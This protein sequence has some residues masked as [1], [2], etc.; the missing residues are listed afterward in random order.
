[1]PSI[2]EVKHAAERQA[3]GVMIDGLIKNLKN[4]DDRT[5]TYLKIVG[6]AQKYFGKAFTPEKVEKVKKDVSDPDNRWM[7]FINRTIDEINPNFAKMTLLNLGYEAFLRGTKMIRENREKYNCNIP[8][9]ILFD[10]TSACNMHCVGCWSGTYGH[11]N[12]LSFEDMDKIVTEG[13][14]L[15]VYL[16]LMT[17]GEPM[18]RKKD[19]LRLIEKHHDCY[20]AAF[21]NSTLI[22]EDF[23]KEL[24]RLGNM[25]FLLSIEGTPDTNDARRGTGHYAEVMRAM[26]LLKKYGILFG[27]SVCY[28][29]QNV[30]AVTSDDFF[31]LLEEKGAKFGFYFHYMPIGKNAVPALM[32]TPEQRKYMIDRIRYIR[33]DK[34]DIQFYPMDFQNDGEYVGGCIAGGRNYF[35]INSSGDAEPCVF[36]H[37]SNANIHDQSVL[38]ILKSPL[39]MMYHEGQPFN[40]NHLR[41]CPMLENPELLRKMVKETGAHQTNEEAPESVEELCAKCDDYAAKWKPMAEKIWSEETHKEATYENYTKLHRDHPE[42]AAFEQPDEKAV[43]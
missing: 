32:P 42:L 18:V 16:Y 36:I 15:G 11:K 39:F 25:T 10:P 14:K 19:L 9:L 5:K 1:M 20:F 8:W 2:E 7:K 3:V 12:N 30:E 29:S 31:H 33:S 43:N 13:K 24:V 27:T 38:E 26:D 4:S 6:L 21:S 22:D 35:H 40:R 23:C 28:T 37:F 41:P 17:G 34:S